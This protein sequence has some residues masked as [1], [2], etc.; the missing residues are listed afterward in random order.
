[1]LRFFQKEQFHIKNWMRTHSPYSHVSTAQQKMRLTAYLHQPPWF[2]Q[3]WFLKAGLAEWGV[4]GLGNI[5]CICPLK[6]PK[7][8]EFYWKNVTNFR[9][10]CFP[11][12]H[13]VFCDSLLRPV[14]WDRVYIN[15]NTF[16]FYKTHLTIHIMNC[17]WRL[18][19]GYNNLSRFQ[20]GSLAVSF[21]HSVNINHGPDTIQTHWKSLPKRSLGSDRIKRRERRNVNIA[22]QLLRNTEDIVMPLRRMLRDLETLGT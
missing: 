13:F 18:L 5:K 16:F 11:L 15:E 22:L 14:A 17:I 3:K 10:I 8:M 2:L 19:G 20:K 7:E 1:M 12:T 6:N 21:I 4:G 9:I